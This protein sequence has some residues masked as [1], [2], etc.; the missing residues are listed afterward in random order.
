M[1]LNCDMGE[2]MGDM[3]EKV[4]PYVDMA[5][6]ASGFHASNPQLMASTIALAVAHHVTIGAHPSYPDI[7]GFGRREMNLAADEIKNLVLYQ[8]GAL[9]ALCVAQSTTVSYVKPH[10]A[11]YHAMMNDDVVLEAI[12][13]ALSVLPQSLSLMVLASSRSDAIQATANR[14]GVPLLFEAFCDR[15]YT[16]TGDL[17]ARGEPNAVLKCDEDIDRRLHDCLTQQCIT[18]ID[19]KSLAIRA[20]TLCVHGDNE[21]ALAIVKKARA[22]MSALDSD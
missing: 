1:K 2:G 10:G 16:H 9:Q 20:D 21:Q 15:A 12:L 19:G 7:E 17:V 18:S 14:Y 3:D 6:I 5:N 4:M 13:S 22:M 11:L 8:V